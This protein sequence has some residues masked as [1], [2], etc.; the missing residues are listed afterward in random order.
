[1]AGEEE[2]SGSVVRNHKAKKPRVKP[3]DIVIEGKFLY[4]LNNKYNLPKKLPL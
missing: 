1:M 2:I 3:H 4:V